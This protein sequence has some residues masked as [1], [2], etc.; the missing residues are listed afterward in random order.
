MGRFPLVDDLSIS[1]NVRERQGDD[2][3]GGDHPSQLG[4]MGEDHV[5]WHDDDE[6]G[7]RDES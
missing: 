6:Q 5:G 7:N 1:R 3:G 4:R 2:A